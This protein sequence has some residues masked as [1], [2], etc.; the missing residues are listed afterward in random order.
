MLQVSSLYLKN[1][2]RKIYGNLNLAKDSEFCA[3]SLQ[4][5]ISMILV[6]QDMW[7]IRLDH[8]KGFFQRYQ[9]LL[10]ELNL[11]SLPLDQSQRRTK[12]DFSLYKDI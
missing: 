3:D 1:E 12:V 4:E 11:R 2:S 5:T 8:N 6:K 10:Y 9:S 7:I